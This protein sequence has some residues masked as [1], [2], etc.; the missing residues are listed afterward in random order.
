[1]QGFKLCLSQQTLFAFAFDI[2]DA[3]RAQTWMRGIAAHVLQVMPATVAFFTFTL[4]NNNTQ[5][6]A[7]ADADF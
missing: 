5:G 3:T 1:M 2:V 6:F 7:F 4:V